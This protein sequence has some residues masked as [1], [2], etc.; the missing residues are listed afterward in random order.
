MKLMLDVLMLMM[1][2]MFGLGMS[3]LLGWVGSTPRPGSFPCA[4]SGP[5]TTKVRGAGGPICRG[6]ACRNCRESPDGTRAS[7]A[8]ISLSRPTRSA[9]RTSSDRCVSPSFCMMR[10]R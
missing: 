5:G 6:K 8:Q 4:G 10:A 9:K 3:H 1:F 2:A 7:P